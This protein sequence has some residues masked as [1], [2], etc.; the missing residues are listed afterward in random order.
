MEINSVN[1]TPDEALLRMIEINGWEWRTIVKVMNRT[2][3]SEH[4]IEELKSIYK[5]LKDSADTDT[6]GQLRLSTD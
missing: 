6:F 2:F 3:H 1:E 4:T 5:S